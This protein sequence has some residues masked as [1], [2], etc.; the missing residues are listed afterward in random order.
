MPLTSGTMVSHYRIVEKIGAGGMGEVYLAED[1]KLH[2]KVALKFL[3]LHLCQD[4][5]CR[6]RFTREAEAAAQLD[7]PNIVSVFEVGE[8]Q[9]RPFFSMQHVEGQSLKEV[10]AGK[11]LPLERII[12]IG[13][14]ICEGLQAAHEKGITHRDIKPSN[15]L[16]DTHGRARIVDFG[17]AS[18]MGSD[19]LTK[20]GSTL[21]TVGYMSPEQVRGESVDYRTD[22]FSLGIVLY[23][24]VTGRQPFKGESDAATSRNITDL[25]PEPLARY[26]SEISAEIQRII[27]KALAKDRNLRYQHADDI[28]ADLKREKDT[29]SGPRSQLVSRGMFSGRGRWLLATCVALVGVI[30]AVLGYV[31]FS[32]RPHQYLVPQKRQLTFVGDATM[33]EISP[34]GGFLA[35]VRRSASGNSQAVWVQD[36]A[37]GAT[38]KVFEDKGLNDLLWSPDGSELLLSAYN[39]SISSMVLVPRLGGSHRRYPI[40]GEGHRSTWSPD[41]SKF[42]ATGVGKVFFVDKKSGDTSSIAFDFSVWNIDWSPNGEFLAF[43]GLNDS[44][45]FISSYNLRTNATQRLVDSLQPMH[46]KWSA[47][48][49]AIYFMTNKGTN[50]PDFYKIRVNPRSGER[51]GEPILLISSLQGGQY[52]YSISRD[53]RK[54]VYRQSVSSSNLWIT[55]A[56]WQSDGV[57]KT[58]Q[59]TW[60]TSAVSEPTFSPDGKRIAYVGRQQGQKHIFVLA[61][62]GGVSEQITRTGISNHYPAWSPD[63]KRLAYVTLVG[64]ISKVGVIDAKGGMPKLLEA[65][66]G[67]MAWCPGQRIVYANMGDCELL[68][69]ESGATEN[70]VRNDADDGYLRTPQYSPDGS[71]VALLTDYEGQWNAR[72]R[73]NNQLAT[74]SVHDH[75]KLWSVPIERNIDLLGWSRDGKWLYLIMSDTGKT[76]ISRMRIDDG[77]REY[78]I[79][80]PWPDIFEVVMAPDCSTFACVRGQS[81]SDIWMIENFDPDVK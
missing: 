2:R 4:P 40:V 64:G 59:L 12:E 56:D 34:D 53:N 46:V 17:L 76:S 32:G 50:P 61:A 38:I 19:H 15:I 30:A 29:T 52:I 39:D 1:T 47:S 25:T 57:L 74:F 9:G 16:I 81:Q 49:N 60:G 43:C 31:H 5:E 70:L 55:N 23:E 8:F 75:V 63:G 45:W 65:P 20:T 10:I 7:H 13:I 77:K 51:E 11:T 68:D 33:P 22:I 54:M 27:S 79:G 48:G 18:V 24:L 73:V 67:Y 80:L 36:L 41:G 72:G 58:K 6:A 28:L 14:Q 26:K 37:T 42:A 35:Y 44:G 78:V 62:D 66:G 69:P 71:K 21:G 3:P